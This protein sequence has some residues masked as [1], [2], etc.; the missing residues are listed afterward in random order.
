MLVGCGAVALVGLAVV[1]VLVA[2]LVPAMKGPRDGAGRA[3]CKNNLRQIG[4]ACHLYAD[5]GGEVFPVGLEMLVPAYVDNPK[6]F[7]CQS[8]RRRRGGASAAPGVPVVDYEYFAGRDAALPGEF[9][10]AVD[11][12]LENHGGAGFNVLFVDAHVEWWPAARVAELR[13]LV[14]DEDRAV[15][16]IRAEPK[17]RAEIIEAWRKARDGAG[18]PPPAAPGGG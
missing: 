11:K 13:R 3:A 18:A 4:I 5:D 15:E 8:A 2:L 6:I 16:A 14:A 12:D 10:L 1:A 7:A 9:L 17:K